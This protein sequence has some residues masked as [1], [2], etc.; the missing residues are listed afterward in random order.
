V[1]R[2]IIAPAERVTNLRWGIALLLG[3]TAIALVVVPVVSTA[4]ANRSAAIAGALG[5]VAWV[6]AG[7]LM[8]RIGVEKAGR[9]VTGALAVLALLAPWAGSVAV[10]YAGLGS[11]VLVLVF[12]LFAKA[13]AYWFPRSERGLATALPQ[14][15]GALAA[16][17]TVSLRQAPPFVSIG[18][19]IIAIACL[20]N[21][22]AFFT[23]YRDPAE[24]RSLTHAEREYLDSGGA[25]DE[26]SP[27]AGAIWSL[28][29]RNKT[30]GLIIAAGAGAYQFAA[31][32]RNSVPFTPLLSLTFGLG[33]LVVGGLLIDLLVRRGADQT[34]VRRTIFGVALVMGLAATVASNSGLGS[35]PLFQIIAI[36]CAGTLMVV[37]A[38]VPGLIAERGTTATL[39]SL[40]ALASVIGGLVGVL[41]SASTAALPLAAVAAI[42]GVLSFIFILGPIEPPQELA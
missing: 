11:L 9:F 22:A 40:A 30:W 39:S 7:V 13:T 23:F 14:A 28:F 10:L 42:V 24:H 5:F 21:A 16:A 6:P 27:R 37:T 35:G 18:W 2:S 31:A 38:A 17:A 3:M 34:G 12:P 20:A 8:D 41:G 19:I 4:G 33:M 26:G 32:M 15:A 25:Q 29:V 1:Q 36:A